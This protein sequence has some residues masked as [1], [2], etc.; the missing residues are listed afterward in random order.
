[1]SLESFNTFVSVAEDC[2][3]ETGTIPKPKKDGQQTVV[4]VQYRM[5]VEEPYQ[6]TQ[7]EILFQSSSLMRNTSGLTKEEKADLR[8]EFL[9]KSQA[10]L[11]ASPMGKTYGWGIHFDD[12]GR[13]VAY[14]RE[15]AEYKEFV[16]NSSIEQTRAMRTK[17]A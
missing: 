9:S 14:G 2:K 6:H 17:K 1:M 3:A 7:E 10:C 16:N 5:L 11:R 15:T 12:K 4:E 8:A 13:A